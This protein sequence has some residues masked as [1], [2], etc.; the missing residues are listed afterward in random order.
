MKIIGF[1]NNVGLQ[2]LGSFDAISFDLNVNCSF[3]TSRHNE[4]ISLTHNHSYFNV[5]SWVQ[6]PQTQL[7]EVSIT[8]F[9]GFSFFQ[10]GTR[11]QDPGEQ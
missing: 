11:L 2:T 8:V 6:S 3:K 4:K 9:G 10:T 5:C 7:S 1:I